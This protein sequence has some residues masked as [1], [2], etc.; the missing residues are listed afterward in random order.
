MV[1]SLVSVILNAACVF[2]L[3]SW[4]A[5]PVEAGEERSHAVR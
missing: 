5:R 4:I 3:R 2:L 1:V